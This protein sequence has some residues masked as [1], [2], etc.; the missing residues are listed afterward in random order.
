MKGAFGLLVI[1]LVIW[2][3]WMSWEWLRN[4]NKDNKNSK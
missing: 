4:R 1:A 3:F 2:G